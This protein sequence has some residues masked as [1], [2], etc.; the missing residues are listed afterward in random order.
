MTLGD[1]RVW[2][3]RRN[4]TIDKAAR[5]RGGRVPSPSCMQPPE[6]HIILFEEKTTPIT[7]N[8][9]IIVTDYFRWRTKILSRSQ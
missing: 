9:I 1:Y 6:K 2:S 8:T 5:I 3:S 7:R 4:E